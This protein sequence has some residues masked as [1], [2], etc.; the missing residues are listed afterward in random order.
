MNIHYENTCPRCG[1]TSGC[2][3]LSPCLRDY[4]SNICIS[5]W[6]TAQYELRQKEI[7]IEAKKTPAKPIEKKSMLERWKSIKNDD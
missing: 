1:G 7:R 6:E 3:C 2:G 5:C 4:T